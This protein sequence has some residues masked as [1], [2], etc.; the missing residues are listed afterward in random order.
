MPKATL[1]KSN[2]L[3]AVQ[4]FSSLSNIRQ[5]FQLPTSNFDF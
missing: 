2:E 3:P 4:E 5:E 1:E